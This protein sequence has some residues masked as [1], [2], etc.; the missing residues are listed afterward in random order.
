MPPPPPPNILPPTPPPDILP[1]REIRYAVCLI[2]FISF[3]F[4]QSQDG[5]RLGKLAGQN[6]E[7]HAS[8]G[9]NDYP[10]QSS[11]F[12][13]DFSPVGALIGE[14]GTLGTATLIAPNTIIT[15]AHVVKNS[16]NDSLPIQKLGI[17]SFI[18]L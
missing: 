1:S 14:N 4:G 10:Y 13:P 3:S 12:F 6:W 18:R 7:V 11:E 17:C 8:I 2:I 5:R 16:Y 15:A 9:K